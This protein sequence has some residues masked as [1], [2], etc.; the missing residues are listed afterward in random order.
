MDK[1]Q[2]AEKHRGFVETDVRDEEGGRFR[3]EI[4]QDNERRTIHCLT[5]N[6]FSGYRP[7]ADEEIEVS[8][9]YRTE[10]TKLKRNNYFEVDQIAKI[11]TAEV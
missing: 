11:Q 8:G 5:I 10:T 3:F 9:C 6:G 2:I 7:E 1:E 4:W